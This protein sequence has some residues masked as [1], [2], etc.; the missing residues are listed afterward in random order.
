MR[1]LLLFLFALLLA[2]PSRAQTQPDTLHP[3][4]PDRLLRYTYAN[5]FLGRTDYYFTQGMTLT[6]VLPSLARLPTQRLLLRGPAGSTQY[7]GL[8]LRYDGFTPLRIQDPFIRVGDRPY[9]S[10]FYA[11]FFRVSNQPTRRQRL[12]TALEVGFIGPGTFAKEF[13]QAIHRATNNPEPR[14]WDYQIGTDAVLGY[15]VAYERQLLA[16]SRFVEVLGTAEASVGTLYTYAGAGAQLRLGLLQPYFSSLGVAGAATVP[17]SRNGSSMAIRRSRAVWWVTMPRCR[18]AFSIN[19]TLMS[20]RPARWRVRYC[21]TPPDWCWRTKASAWRLIQLGYRLS[22][23]EPA[24]TAGGS[25][26]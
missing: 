23:T 1:S 25:W 24:R 14:G 22:S 18:A 26:W 8:T 13:Q 7:H 12:T 2:A 5:D 4:S 3:T 9:A 20:F 16:V 6:L 15:R 21:A 19:R 17:G 10:Y 11:S